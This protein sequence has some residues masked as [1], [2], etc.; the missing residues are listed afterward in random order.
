MRK[1]SRHPKSKAKD[2]VFLT[3]M[4]PK[5]NSGTQNVAKRNRM[6]KMN[7]KMFGRMMIKKMISIQ[8]TLLPILMVFS[9]INIIHRL[10]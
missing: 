9:F 8:I 4:S 7:T 1:K 6:T 2:L 3:N 10:L 5:L